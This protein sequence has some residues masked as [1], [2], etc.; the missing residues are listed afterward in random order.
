MT[1]N[2]TLYR[3]RVFGKDGRAY[4]MGIAIIWIFFFHFYCW[5]NGTKPWWLYFL[6]EGQ[7]GV[8][9]FLFLSAYGLEASLSKNNWISFYLNRIKRIIPVYFLFLFTLF[10]LFYNHVPFKSVFIQ[11]FGQLTGYSLFQ[12][13][14]FFSTSFEFD[15]FTPAL[16]VLYIFFPFIS[17]GLNHLSKQKIKWEILTLLLLV[18][19]SLFDLRSIQLPIKYLIYRLPIFML[20]TLTY[21]HLKN[22]KI[23]RLLILYA[24]FFICGA[25]SNQHWFIMSSSIP[26]FLAVY[27]MIQGKRPFLESISKLGRHSYEIY[28][29]H[30]FPV[31]N[32]LKLIVFENIY[33]HILVTI[34][35]TIII[36]TLYSIFQAYSSKV[37][38]SL[39]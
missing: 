38:N 27:A 9:I 37:I 36:A 2:I 3:E 29:A 31:T 17:N 26:I 19:I 7:T 39:Y 23:N 5:F 16:I 34:A 14:E 18:I 4:L 11:C 1:N 12:A 28:L 8:D 32:F 35:W 25:F 24:V 6:S 10:G 22:E 15:W 20:G 21:I 30:I 13:P 33:I